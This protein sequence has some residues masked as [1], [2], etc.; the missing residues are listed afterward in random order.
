MFRGL[1]FR[2]YSHPHVDRIE[3][4]IWG[5]YYDITKAIFHLLKGDYSLRITP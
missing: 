2:V 1:G 5:A 3:H 4:G